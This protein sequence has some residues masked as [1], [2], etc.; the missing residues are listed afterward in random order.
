MKIINLVIFFM[1]FTVAGGIL[2]LLYVN[3]S[4]KEEPIPQI[5]Q[6]AQVVE[7][8]KWMDLEYEYLG[9]TEYM[10]NPHYYDMLMVEPGEPFTWTDLIVDDSRLKTIEQQYAFTVPVEFDLDFD[11]YILLVV[12]GR[13]IRELQSYNGIKL[14]ITY[15]QDYQG[16]TVFFYRLI[17]RYYPPPFYGDYYLMDGDEKVYIGDEFSP[18]FIT[19]Q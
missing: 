1:V 15:G 5:V 16:N 8:A 13:E 3:Y 17:K 9:K 7:Q 6:L 14:A 11:Q 12:F 10:D 19:L 2:F 4:T 18:A